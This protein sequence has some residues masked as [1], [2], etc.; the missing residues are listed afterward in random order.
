MVINGKEYSFAYT[1]GVSCA[2]EERGI[3]KMSLTNS[4]VE[5]ALLMNKAYEDRLKFDDPEYKVNY[6][7]REEL[8]LQDDKIVPVLNKELS[9]VCERDS[10]ISVLTAPVKKKE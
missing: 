4:L 1:V 10:R 7:S 2:K 8:L 9:E 6:L 3:A 5:M